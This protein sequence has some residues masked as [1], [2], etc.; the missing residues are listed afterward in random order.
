M[1]KTMTLFNKVIKE[2]EKASSGVTEAQ[3]T[4]EAA[5]VLQAFTSDF[6]S[7]VSSVARPLFE[8]FVSDAL[9]NGFPSGIEEGADGY[10]NPFISVRFIPERGTAFGVNRS[11]ECS[12]VLKGILSEQKVEHEACFD[13]RKGIHGVTKD[14]LEIQS[15]S[16]SVLENLLTKF[17]RSSLSTKDRV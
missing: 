7:S 16:K 13:Q 3:E 17:L 2:H 10:G 14:K 4:K 1:E 6:H 8:E 12:F 15:I 9:R 5:I 11:I